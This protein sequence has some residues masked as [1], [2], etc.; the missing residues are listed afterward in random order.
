[1]K[2]SE[3][4]Q[5]PL[6]LNSDTGGSSSSLVAKRKG[7]GTTG[8][9]KKRSSSSLLRATLRNNA[10]EALHENIPAFR[11][12]YMPWCARNKMIRQMY[13]GHRVATPK[14]KGGREVMVGVD[15]NIPRV[16]DFM[17]PAEEAVKVMHL[18]NGNIQKPWGTSL[19]YLV[20]ASSNKGDLGIMYAIKRNQIFEDI[21]KDYADKVDCKVKDMFLTNERTG[22]VISPHDIAK[23]VRISQ[24]DMLVANHK[25][26]K[27]NMN[28]WIKKFYITDVSDKPKKVKVD[29]QL[30]TKLCNLYHHCGTLFNFDLK[31]VMLMNQCR[32]LIP[33]QTIESAKIR[34]NGVVYA[35]P[36]ARYKK[37]SCVTPQ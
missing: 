35:L 16:A 2:S 21:Y 6:S 32:V 5:P 19:H 1:M 14:R 9:S 28:S 33:N 8:E 34:N 10:F 22:V 26:P 3:K 15:D 18:D 17:R 29:G 31:K 25:N 20:V 7:K 36:N 11:Q 12:E 4:D 23:Y 37:S 27:F 13:C 30:D 24:G